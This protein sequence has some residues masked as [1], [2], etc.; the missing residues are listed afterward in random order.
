MSA[1][2][3]TGAG[4]EVGIGL[5]TLGSDGDAGTDLAGAARYAESLGFDHV[6]VADLIV[7]DGTPAL[8]AMVA[9]AVAATATE[10]ARVGVVLA[11]PVRPTVWVT[12]Q[13]QALQRVSGNRILLGVGAGGVPN[14][15]FWRAAG[16]PGR[17]RGRRTDA[18]LRVLRPLIAGEEVRLEDQPHEPAVKLAPGAVVPP[19]LVGGNSEAALRR[20]AAYGDGWIPSQIGPGTLATA[21]VRLRELAAGSGRAAPTVHV[22]GLAVVGDQ[23]SLR[24]ARAARVSFVRSLPGGHGLSADDAI[25]MVT[26]SPAEAADRIAAFRAAGA[27]GVSFSPTTD[28]PDEWRRHCDRAAEARTLVT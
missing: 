8:E 4:I 26:A 15:P 5:P 11:L 17:E 3:G 23:E 7:G 22:G 2:S 25:A 16:V 12:A 1:T 20:A 18:A 9:M 21:V 27:D 10:Q 24:S 6:D 19:I 14:S 13:I 28:T